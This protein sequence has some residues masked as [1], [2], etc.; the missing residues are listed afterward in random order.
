MSFNRNLPAILC[1]AGVVSFLVFVLW[2]V[3]GQGYMPFNEDESIFYNSGRLFYETGSIKGFNCVDE[4]FSIVFSAN[5]YGIMYNI[6][7]GG[8]AKITGFNNSYFIW[9]NIVSVILSVPFILM[10]A[11]DGNKRFL[12]LAAFFMFFMVPGYCFTYFPEAPNIFFGIVLTFLLFGIAKNEEAAGL[13]ILYALLC[14][15]FALFRVTWIFWLIGLLPFMNNF[16]RRILYIVFTLTAIGLAFLYVQYCSAPYLAQGG[17]MIMADLMKGHVGDFIK[18][19]FKHLLINIDT[20]VFVEGVHVSRAFLPVKF[21]SVLVSVW[22]FISIFFLKDKFVKAAALIWLLAMAVMFSVY[23]TVHPYFLK[24]TA[25]LF[26]LAF[27][28]VIHSGQ[29][30]MLSLLVLALILAFPFVCIETIHTISDRK[31]AFVEAQTIYAPILKA[32]REIGAHLMPM[33]ETIIHT[34]V[35]EYYPMPL[36]FYLCNLPA[37]VP[38]KQTVRYTVSK[39]G[40]G[41]PYEANFNPKHILKVDYLLARK[42]VA[43]DDVRLVFNNDY[44]YLYRF[45]D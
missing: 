1:F 18:G 39:Y 37:S 28:A 25:S 31:Q 45:L 33:R 22:L 2:Y 8:I 3:M 14:F 4:K 11:P 35:Y 43:R 27:F 42:P 13:K 21:F 23:A 7:Y 9:I 41:I 17:G 24:V 26:L 19:I 30:V 20:Y 36:A 29:K 6:F 34:L 12:M 10:L 38:Q 40:A 15:L 44:F 32:E 16:A 5:W